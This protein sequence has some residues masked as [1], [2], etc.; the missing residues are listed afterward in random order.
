MIEELDTHP[1]GPEVQEPGTARTRRADAQLSIIEERITARHNGEVGTGVDREVDISLKDLVN[2]T[3]E[4][5]LGG[6]LSAE[7]AQDML[8]IALEKIDEYKDDDDLTTNGEKIA[9]ALAGLPNELL[10]GA[11]QEFLRAEGSDELADLLSEI[12]RNN[13]NSLAA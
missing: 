1:D 6:E 2:R 10:G 7:K 11:L 3:K 8:L 4:A 13:P 9:G 12:G 5:W